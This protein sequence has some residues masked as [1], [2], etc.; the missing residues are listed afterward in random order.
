MVLFDTERFRVLLIVNIAT[1]SLKNKIVDYYQIFDPANNL[2]IMA[3]SGARGNMSQVRQ[4]VGMR[5]LMSDQEG[6]Y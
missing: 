6:N 4:L 5:G 3:F 2:Y 1:E